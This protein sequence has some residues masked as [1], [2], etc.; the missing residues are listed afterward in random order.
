MVPTVA[1]P[2]AIPFTFQV[3]PES[4]GPVTLTVKNCEVPLTRTSA[5]GDM[6]IPIGE[7]TVTLALADADVADA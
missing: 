4:I 3:T 5:C 6:R 2:P 1:S 7:T